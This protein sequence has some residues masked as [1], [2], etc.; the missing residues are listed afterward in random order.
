MA[1][2]K[3]R[4]AQFATVSIDDMV[5]RCIELIL[6]PAVEILPYGF[7]R[8]EKK[9]PV[10][11]KIKLYHKFVFLTHII[12]TKCVTAKDNKIQLHSKRLQNVLGIY[13]KYILYTLKLLDL[14]DIDEKY[15][16]DEYSRHISV[17]NWNI[18]YTESAN[19][20]VSEYNSKWEKYLNDDIKRNSENKKIKV[21]FS[22]GRPILEFDGKEITQA[23]KTFYDNYNDSLSLLNLR[24]CK[25]DSIKYIESLC[26]EKNT[27]EYNYYMHSILGF[28]AENNKIISID[29][30]GRIYNYLTNLKRELK[31]LF[32]IKFQLDVA[33]C[34]PLLICK[35][36][37]NRYN[38]NNDIL[39]YIYNNIKKGASAHNVIE[40]LCKTLNT[41]NIKIPLDVLEF[42]YIC[43][44]G[45][46]WDE[47]QAS[48]PELS[49][50][51]VK[52]QTF[53]QIIYNSK[54]AELTHF[55]RRFIEIYP[56]VY[57]T[58]SLYT[59]KLSL[60]IMKLE[61][62]IM[63]MILEECYLRNWKVINIH[64]AVVVLDVAENEHVT[65]E[66]LIGII[67]D[68]FFRHYLFPAV[69]YEEPLLPCL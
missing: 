39:T 29:K 46:L 55:G 22:E 48:F 2:R 13:Y 5:G 21:R 58:I 31:C 16:K 66:E 6:T 11:T 20:K 26:E 33:N 25:E 68:K 37:T 18:S 10:P 12:I 36:L 57:D 32:N 42:I 35:I 19:Q 4:I 49:R 17:L 67:K 28:S 27:H 3:I 56:N 62:D 40:N 23:E 44:K 61:S 8:V 38:I 52:E 65:P 59:G 7:E 14:I 41:S 1:T 54:I 50:S 60:K 34:H 47:L 53:G 15:E 24:V 30:Q 63:R 69:H 43:S 45:T 64:D 51:R 9:I